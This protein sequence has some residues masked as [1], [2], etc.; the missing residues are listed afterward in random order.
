M[1]SVPKSILVLSDSR[2]RSSCQL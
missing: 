2:L 1:Y